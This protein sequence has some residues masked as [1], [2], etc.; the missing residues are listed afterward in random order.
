MHPKRHTGRALS[1]HCVSFHGDGLDG[2][3]PCP[4]VAGETGRDGRIDVL[5]PDRKDLG[6]ETR[7]QL[8]GVLLPLPTCR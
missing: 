3:A 6:Q 4:V 8:S 2:G 5:R 7:N 1:V